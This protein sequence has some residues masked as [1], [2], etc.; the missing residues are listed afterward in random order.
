M[1]ET[2]NISSFAALLDLVVSKEQSA[3][4]RVGRDALL[5]RDYPKAYRI[6]E[7]GK[8]LTA[9]TASRP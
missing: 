9:M 3:S 5:P 1:D 8:D 2:G 4:Q 6:A 7:H